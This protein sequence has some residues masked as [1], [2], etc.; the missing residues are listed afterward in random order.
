MQYITV[1]NQA[2]AEL[3]EKRSRFIANVYPVSEEKQALEIIAELKKEYW[4]AMGRT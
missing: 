4:D 3:T 2:S 1:K